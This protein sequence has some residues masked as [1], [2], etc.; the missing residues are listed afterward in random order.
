MSAR[1]SRSTA[2]STVDELTG[3]HARHHFDENLEL[4][5]KRAQRFGRLL[6]LLLV[7]LDDAPELGSQSARLTKN[8]L[9][10]EAGALLRSILRAHDIGCR[11]GVET[12][13]VLLP[14]TD[15]TQACAVAGKVRSMLATHEFF[16]RRFGASLGLSVSQGIA[17]A[18]LKV[19]DTPERLLEAAE[20]A[21][22]DAQA[23]GFDQVRLHESA[24]EDRAIA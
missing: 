16:G 6:S 23:G 3:L 5:F 1:R 10:S 4:E 2:C 18:P 9:L 15:A 21:L 13:A 24:V 11:Y 7:E 20:A 19:V 8:Y 12:L 22:R 17:V 14:E